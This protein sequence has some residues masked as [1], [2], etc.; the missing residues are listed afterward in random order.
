VQSGALQ[1][2]KKK[3]SEEVRVIMAPEL[4]PGIEDCGREDQEDES[5]DPEAPLEIKGEWALN[6]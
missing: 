4:K 1:Q 2:C 6:S 3:G 5:G